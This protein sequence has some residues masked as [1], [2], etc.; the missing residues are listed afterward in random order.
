MQCIIEKK[1]IETIEKVMFYSLELQTTC[2]SCTI[3]IEKMENAF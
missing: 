3:E 1:L 2:S